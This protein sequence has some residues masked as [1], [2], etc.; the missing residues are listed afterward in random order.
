MQ[1]AK[2]KIFMGLIFVLFPAFVLYIC[3][4]DE[5]ANGSLFVYVILVIMILAGMS[6]LISAVK[7]IIK[8]MRVYR[9]GKVYRGKIFRYEYDSGMEINGQPV[10][11]LVIRF[12][13]ENKN[14]REEAFY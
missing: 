14:I 7:T 3:F 9:E 8:A 12:F 13:D 1:Q 10:L 5:N 4:T 6:V 2:V 11:T